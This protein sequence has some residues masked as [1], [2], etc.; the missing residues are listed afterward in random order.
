MNLNRSP[1]S[2]ATASA[3]AVATVGAAAAGY[4]TLLAI[5][6]WRHY[7]AIRWILLLTLA[8]LAGVFLAS[9][10]RSMRGDRTAKA[11][12]ATI[13]GLQLVT[14]ATPVLSYS[15]Y[16]GVGLFVEVAGPESV[17]F[18]AGFGGEIDIRTSQQT[19]S[20]SVGVNVVA[21]LLLLG[22][23]SERRKLA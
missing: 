14:F 1:S 4:E 10:R 21:V 20:S 8:C 23:R 15:L 19:T 5:G 11:V 17:R 3:L 13:L 9:A 18:E 16:L 6:E 2:S 12:L 7:G 22:L